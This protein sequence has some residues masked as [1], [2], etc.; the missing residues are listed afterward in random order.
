MHRRHLGEL[1][2]ER[3]QG[4]KRCQEELHWLA[5]ALWQRL[6]LHLVG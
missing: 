4:C 5:P 3:L 1:G 2:I 6:D